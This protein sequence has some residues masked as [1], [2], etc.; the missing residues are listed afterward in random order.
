ME[1]CLREANFDLNLSWWVVM[2]DALDPRWI[3]DSEGKRV[4]LGGLP[5]LESYGR[6]S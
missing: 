3:E 5:Q 6:C 4:K 1:L 2:T